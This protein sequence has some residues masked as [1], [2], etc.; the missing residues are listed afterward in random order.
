MGCTERRFFVATSIV[1]LLAVG[2]TT[3][4]TASARPDGAT[5][6]S[7]SLVASPT[8]FAQR[9]TADDARGVGLRGTDSWHNA[10]AL[11]VLAGTCAIAVAF[12]SAA[13]AQRTD[14]QVP[15]RVRRR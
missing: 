11:I 12:Y 5:E 13:T 10:I 2:V 7:S 3:G 14:T 9:I 4:A 15:V 1:V 8:A 6:P